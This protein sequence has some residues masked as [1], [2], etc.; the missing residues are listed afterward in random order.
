MEN[1]HPLLPL[2]VQEPNLAQPPE[3]QSIPQQPLTH[4]Q[5]VLQSQPPQLS[6][7]QPP[8]QAQQAPLQMSQTH[9]SPQPHHI[10]HSSLQQQH[11][12]LHLQAQVQSSASPHHILLTQHQIQQ[13]LQNHLSH[14]PTATVSDINVAHATSSTLQP[15]S[16]V[17]HLVSVP[18]D[19]VAVHHNR[20][21]SISSSMPVPS[22]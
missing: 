7:P 15:I 1:Q 16:S 21:N 4:S 17:F 5:Q 12:P 13:T 3:I 14:H 6:A 19:T 22:L 11:S 10:I 2:Q 20:M 9:Q 18:S 8:S